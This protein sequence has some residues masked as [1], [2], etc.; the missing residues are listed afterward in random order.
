MMQ[1]KKVAKKK[2]RKRRAKTNIGFTVEMSRDH[3]AFLA[4]LAALSEES[5]AT[6]AKVILC[7]G[8]ISAQPSLKK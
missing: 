3:F 1:K 7:I 8:I 4:Q 6:V 5:I 2:T